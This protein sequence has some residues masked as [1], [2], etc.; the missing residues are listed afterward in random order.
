MSYC[1]ISQRP[2]GLQY[3]CAWS[4][5]AATQ[6]NYYVLCAMR[7]RARLTFIASQYS[8]ERHLRLQYILKGGKGHTMRFQH[9]STFL[10]VAG[11]VVVCSPDVARA[12]FLDG[13]SNAISSAADTVSNGVTSA[14]STVTN[15]TEGATNTV[16]N[17]VNTAVGS[18]SSALNTAA[19]AVQQG[20]DTA[21]G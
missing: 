14:V 10:L 4:L 11:L 18:V 12:G 1:R 16:T 3:I 13:I 2:T 17:G 19:G 6:V 7:S 8:R 15:V 5:H 21:T 9:I 20:L